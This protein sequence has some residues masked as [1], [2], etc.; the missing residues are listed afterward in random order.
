MYC[1]VSSG[2]VWYFELSPL[3]CIVLRYSI[4]LLSSCSKLSVVV[5]NIGVIV[6]RMFR[7]CRSRVGKVVG[8]GVVCWLNLFSSCGV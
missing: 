2:C 5:C 6:K 1:V 7:G 4:R 8:G 3:G